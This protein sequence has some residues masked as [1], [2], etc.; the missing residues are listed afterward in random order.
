MTLRI[1]L[2]LGLTFSLSHSPPEEGKLENLN[3]WSAL[4]GHIKCWAFPIFFA[5]SY[6]LLVIRAICLLSCR[7]Y[8]WIKPIISHRARFQG[9]DEATFQRI[10]I[11]QILFIYFYCDSFGI[12]TYMRLYVV[13]TTKPQ[14]AFD[15]RLWYNYISNIHAWFCVVTQYLHGIKCF[16]T[17]VLYKI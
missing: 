12:S 9:D 15:F 11:W 1:T 8:G 2:I 3:C 4:R 16:V 13:H 10:A 14:I 7:I 6:K 5:G 17:E